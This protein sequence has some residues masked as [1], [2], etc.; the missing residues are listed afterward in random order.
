[1]KIGLGTAQ[2]GM[3]YGISNCDGK[4]PEQEVASILD[5]ASQ[6]GIRIIDTA[7]L[8]G[9]SEEVLGKTLPSGIDFKIVTKT[10]RFAKSVIVGTDAHILEETLYRSLERLRIPSVFGLLIH[11]ADDV[12]AVGG[13]C[14]IDMMQSLKVRGLVRKIGISIYTEAQ[15]D[16]VL[17]KFDIDLIQVPINIFD[18]RLLQSGHLASAKS[19][20]IEI[21]SRSAFLQGLLL[22]NH[23][24]IP[25]QLGSMKDHLKNYQETIRRMGLT[26]VQ[27][28]LGFVLG[29]E[30]IDSVICGVNNRAQLEEMC[31]SAR[32]LE[33][34]V[35]TQ[36][37]FHDESIINPSLWKF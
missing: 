12:L 15:I 19:A 5:L 10:P 7:A 11:H 1:M 2:F 8:Y 9:V 16:S 6:N 3:D 29:L 30:E 18:Q 23:E 21:H 28:A 36:F 13:N 14:L 25:S 22:M 27:A 33:K 34:E 31:R 24:N 37:A 26:P 35:F 20:G 4:T 17:E 32:P